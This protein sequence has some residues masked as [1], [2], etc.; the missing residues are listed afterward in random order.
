M[1]RSSE[2]GSAG[3][4]PR[5]QTASYSRLKLKTFISS[6]PRRRESRGLK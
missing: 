1:E 2:N 6:F 5:F 3:W 4:Q